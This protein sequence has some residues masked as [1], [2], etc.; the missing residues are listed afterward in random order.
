MSS[1][2]AALPRA[3]RQELDELMSEIAFQKVLL[4]SIDDSVANRAEAEDEVRAEIK[5]LEKKLRALKHGTSTTASQS[6]Q[7][8][9]SQIV[10]SA[11][12]CSTPQKFI[13]MDDSATSSGSQGVFT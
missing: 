13:N 10:E 2:Q 6:A 11:S 7:L 12:P 3:Q 9:S 8:H 5:T 4:S 1:S